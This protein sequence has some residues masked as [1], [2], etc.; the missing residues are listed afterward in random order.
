LFCVGLKETVRDFVL[1]GFI[2]SGKIVA[3]EKIGPEIIAESIID[4]H[5]VVL[6]CIEE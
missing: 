1:S 2:T 6:N 4:R 5:S 3:R